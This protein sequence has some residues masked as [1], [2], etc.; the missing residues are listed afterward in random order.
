MLQRDSNDLGARRYS[1]EP[2]RHLNPFVIK[3]LYNVAGY[4]NVNLLVLHSAPVD[5]T[6]YTVY[7]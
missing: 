4:P 1:R 7:T 5:V 2:R 3:L 6:M